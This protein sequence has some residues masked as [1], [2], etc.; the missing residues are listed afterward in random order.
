MRSMTTVPRVALF[1]DSY[2]EANGVARTAGALEAFAAERDRPLLIVHGG[3]ADQ[4]IESGSVT[5]LELA[6]WRSTSFALEHDLRFDIALWRH[7]RRVAQVLRWFRPDVLHY[8]GPSDV[9]QMGAL[10]GHRL[11]IPIVGSWH[12]NL[13]E[14][15][16]RRLLNRLSAAD[17]DTRLRVRM[18]VERH[19]LAIT[20]LFYK[21]PRVLLAPNDEWKVILESR[22][23]KP[24]FVMTRG[25]D[26][27]AFAPSRRTRTDTAINI[28]YVGRLSVEKN[29]RALATVRDALAANGLSDARFTVVGDGTER[30]WLQ[31][32]LPGAEFCG[33]LHGE[34]LA[35]AYANFD[36][37]VFPSETETVGNVVLEAMA[38]G[39][40]VVAMARGGPKFIA[41]S[42]ASAVLVHSERE[43]AEATLRLVRDPDRRHAMGAAARQAA[44]ARAW[45]P[46]FDT[47]YRAYGVAITASN[48]AGRAA[49]RSFDAVSEE[50]PAA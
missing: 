44:L 10:L 7:T 43:L 8:T 14:Y 48:A 26:T 19:A 16:S 25:V 1:T 27:A 37:F 28:G 24:T 12:T 22:T 30:A 50:H 3:G 42:P 40:P 5:R 36:L 33:V 49:E 2:Y 4:L 17:E 29:V 9:G 35:A 11:T 34:R 13:H 6:R 46:V 15:A 21:I 38:S 31:A 47:L 45:A 23:R 41:A 32:R 39:V 20:S 18:L